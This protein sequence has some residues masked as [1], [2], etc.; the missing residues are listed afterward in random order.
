MTDEG[1]RKYGKAETARAIQRGQEMTHVL[2]QSQKNY[3]LGVLIAK[4]IL[5]GEGA[6]VGELLKKTIRTTR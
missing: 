6:L 5:D 4:H 3:L 2:T 1:P